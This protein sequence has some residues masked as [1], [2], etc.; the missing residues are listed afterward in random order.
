M[1]QS[2]DLPDTRDL[3]CVFSMRFKKNL[4]AVGGLGLLALSLLFY[5]ALINSRDPVPW[6]KLANRIALNID[7]WSGEDVPLG[8][9]ESI[10]AAVG[11]LNYKDYIYRVYRKGGREVW[12]YAMFWRHGDIAVS[13][14]SAH[15][16]D[17]C[18]VSNGAKNCS[19]FGVRYLDLGN[20]LRTSPAEVR[21]FCFPPDNLRIQAAWWHIWGSDLV[22][23]S[24]ADK[25][26]FSMLREIWFWA[27]KRSGIH[28]DQ[29]L[30]RIH[31][32][33]PLDEA[34]M[35]EPV[36]QFLVS[37]P[38]VMSANPVVTKD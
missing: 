8:A 38:L 36:I 15:T 14:L 6:Q 17:V 2:T 11:R 22:D 30:V 25:T 12:V 23:R 1:F 29:L 31:S 32:S 4:I 35:T 18:W 28:K 24:F 37:I 10:I 7:G 33:M 9:N 20:G 26:I 13:G 34:V 3:G 5:S 19:G 16:P 27:A 21:Q